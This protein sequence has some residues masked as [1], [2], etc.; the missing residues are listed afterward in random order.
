M[1]NNPFVGSWTVS[2][3]PLR[4]RGRSIGHPFGRTGVLRIQPRE[5]DDHG[6]T[7][8]LDQDLSGQDFTFDATWQAGPEGAPPSMWASLETGN[9]M[10]HLFAYLR[11]NLARKRLVGHVELAPRGDRVRRDGVLAD[12]DG[13]GSW[14]AADDSPERP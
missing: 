3:S 8:E 4:E 6:L 2:F 14:I 7:C 10:Y 9:R 11:Q 13:D 12:S 1:N 5:G